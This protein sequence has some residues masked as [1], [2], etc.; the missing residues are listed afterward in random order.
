MKMQFK[1]VLFAFLMTRMVLSIWILTNTIGNVIIKRRKYHY[2]WR[3]SI[4]VQ[5]NTHATNITHVQISQIGINIKLK[6]YA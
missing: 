2:F 6:Q 5:I 3:T 4:L 1:L